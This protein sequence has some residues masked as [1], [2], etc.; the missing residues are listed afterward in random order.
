VTEPE[1]RHWTD[2]AIIAFTN[3]WASPSGQGQILRFARMAGLIRD[4]P[5]S[6]SGEEEHDCGNP[7]CPGHD[8]DDPTRIDN[9]RP[10]D[11]GLVEFTDDQL[12]PFVSRAGLTWCG[13]KD[14]ETFVDDQRY[15]ASNWRTLPGLRAVVV[16]EAEKWLGSI[17]RLTR[18]A[19]GDEVETLWL[20]KNFVDGRPEYWAFDNPY[21]CEES[22][23]PITLGQPCGYA[24]VKPS[25]NGRPEVHD[26][27]VIADI[28]AA[29]RALK[30][31]RVA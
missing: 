5:P 19:S 21:P 7:H 2:D 1:Q 31:S 8:E 22:G 15:F 14:R 6:A 27:T 18:K 20:W 12:R 3:D 10:A 23:D 26:E 11:D 30:G 13:R 29:I 25:I 4:N 9:T 28:L 24:I 16:E 17:T